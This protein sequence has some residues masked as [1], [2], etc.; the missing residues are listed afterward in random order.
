MVFCTGKIF[1]QYDD[2]SNSAYLGR[3]E[4]VKESFYLLSGKNMLCNEK[5]MNKK[6][7]E[8]PDENCIDEAIDEFLA[9]CFLASANN[10]KY[11][12]LKE[13]LNEHEHLGT[14]EYPKTISDTFELLMKTSGDLDS[15]RKVKKSGRNQ[16][17]HNA[18]SVSFSQKSSN[19]NYEGCI[20]GINGL[21]YPTTKCHGCQELGHYSDK[22]PNNEN[23][24]N[25][26]KVGKQGFQC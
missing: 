20:P 24:Q 23:M 15:H 22:C 12:R 10:N 5:I 7:S 18:T 16:K 8:K 3:F 6:W 4:S 9:A 26:V 21:I 2:E 14:D 25:D 17:V 13:N 19:D 1:R 11:G